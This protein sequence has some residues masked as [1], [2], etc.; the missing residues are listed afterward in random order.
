MAHNLTQT[1]I[2]RCIEKVDQLKERGGD[3]DT[4]SGIYKPK[5]SP[6]AIG[7]SAEKTAKIVGVSPRTVE[8][9]RTVLADPEEKAALLQGKKSIHKASQDAKEKRRAAAVTETSPAHF[10]SFNRQPCTGR[11]QVIKKRLAPNR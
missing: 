10:L 3:R 4:E 9:A 1:E 6:Y 11:A 8:R 2:L 7:K 5:A